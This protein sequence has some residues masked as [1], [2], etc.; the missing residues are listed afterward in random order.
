MAGIDAGRLRDR[1]DPRQKLITKA[2]L[3]ML[4]Q[5]HE[6][7]LPSL[8]EEAEPTSP[9]MQTH[10]TLTHVADRIEE[11]IQL[12]TTLLELFKTVLS[13]WENVTSQIP[14]T[15]GIASIAGCCQ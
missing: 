7:V 2:Q 12:H 5:E 3:Q 14:P 10:T 11:V 13:K 9:K 8:D 15:E 6:R 1:A 4:A